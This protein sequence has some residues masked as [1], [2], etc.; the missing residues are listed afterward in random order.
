MT[1]KKAH[2]LTRI[3]NY[4]QEEKEH[5]PRDANSPVTVLPMFLESGSTGQ[6]GWLINI[7]ESGCCISCNEMAIRDADL[8]LVF[9]GLNAKVSARV[10]WRGEFTIRVLFDKELPSAL[11]DRIAALNFVQVKPGERARKAPSLL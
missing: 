4:E 7:S 5:L 9:S 1:R 11:V 2:S 3:G 10:H 6:K 8:Y